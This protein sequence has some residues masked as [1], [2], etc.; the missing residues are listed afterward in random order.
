MILATTLGIV[1]VPLFFVSMMQLS[2]RLVPKNGKSR[3]SGH[4]TGEQRNLKGYESPANVQE[5][6]IA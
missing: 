3:M 6:D 4:N 5:T 2:D 1:L